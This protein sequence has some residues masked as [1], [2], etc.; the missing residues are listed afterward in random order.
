MI[1]SKTKERRY[2]AACRTH[3]VVKWVL[4]R[5]CAF[6]Q[7]CFFF[8]D[9]FPAQGSNKSFCGS[10]LSQGARRRV[11]LYEFTLLRQ[12]FGVASNL[13]VAALTDVDA[14][15]VPNLQSHLRFCRRSLPADSIRRCVA[16]RSADVGNLDSLLPKDSDLRD[17]FSRPAKRRLC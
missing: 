4:R 17:K 12:G 2:D 14:W 11:A 5:V 10:G 16:S 15:R 6:T 1:G 9:A 7:R 8:A 3:R 13:G